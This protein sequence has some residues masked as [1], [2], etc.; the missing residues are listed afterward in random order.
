MF[1]S[2]RYGDTLDSGFQCFH[3]FHLHVYIESNNTKCWNSLLAAS[4]VFVVNVE[5]EASQVIS[6]HF[7]SCYLCCKAP[8]VPFLIAL[9][10]GGDRGSLPC[11]EST[12]LQTVQSFSGA[13]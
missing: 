5:G 6:V 1:V 4:I 10:C 11:E 13:E 7:H 2:E 3:H 9:C 8:E 12:Y